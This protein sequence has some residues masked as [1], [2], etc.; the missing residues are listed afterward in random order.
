MDHQ[1]NNAI[2]F[3]Y[4]MA[5]YPEPLNV[6]HILHRLFDLCTIYKELMKRIVKNKIDIDKKFIGDYETMDNVLVNIE[7]FILIFIE[8][9]TTNKL[10]IEDS[11]LDFIRAIIDNVIEKINYCLKVI[12]KNNPP[13]K[14]NV[15]CDD[16]LD[17]TNDQVDIHKAYGMM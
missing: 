4:L 14:F 6:L 11:D 15:V 16:E 7:N 2:D 5:M 17:M 10:S 1:V 8:E 12:N 13:I 3:K 9:A